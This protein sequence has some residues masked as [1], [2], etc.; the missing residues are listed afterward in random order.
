VLRQGA[1]APL[2]HPLLFAACRHAS[3]YA[4]THSRAL[5]GQPPPLPHAS[6]TAHLALAV[7]SEDT[8]C[9]ARQVKHDVVRPSFALYIRRGCRSMV[10]LCPQRCCLA[11]DVSVGAPCCSPSQAA[12][13]QR[14]PSCK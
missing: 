14:A 2:K 10:K 12:P 1:R 3:T 9:A 5:T 6:H 13:W 4:S 7:N 8:C 11:R